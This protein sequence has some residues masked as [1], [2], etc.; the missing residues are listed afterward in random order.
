MKD[1]L[2]DNEI[3]N[4]SNPIHGN[5]KLSDESHIR[6]ARRSTD[7][8]V[9]SASMSGVMLSEGTTD[10]FVYSKGLTDEEAAVNLN[11]YGL[12]VLPEKKIP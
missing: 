6:T 9:G 5:R 10:T 8:L 11:K 7:S 4:V 12:N 3:G 2:L 1:S